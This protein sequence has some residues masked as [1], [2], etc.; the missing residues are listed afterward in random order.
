MFKCIEAKDEELIK[1]IYRFRYQIA[2]EEDNIFCKDNYQEK[3]E[4]DEYD[5]YSIHYAVLDKEG[6]IAGCM[7]LIHHSP[8]GYPASNHL[9]I[10]EEEKKN[11]LTNDEM[12]ELSRIFIRRDCRGIKSSKRIVEAIKPLAG[13]KLIDLKIVFSFGALEMSFFR[14]LLMLKMPY[15]QIGPYYIYGNRKRALCVMDTK[16][17]SSLNQ[18]FLCEPVS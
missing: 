15:R 12:G 17:F 13:Q 6:E 1:E 16:E 5:K 10:F 14:F 11:L 8:I 9:P 2:C 3:Y 4:T 7:R 18:E